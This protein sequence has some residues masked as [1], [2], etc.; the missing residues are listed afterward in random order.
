MGACC[1][2]SRLLA[3]ALLLVGECS[4]GLGPAAEA[5]AH[6]DLAA[7]AQHGAL[8][9]QV[10]AMVAQLV[11]TVEALR[12]EVLELKADRG[13]SQE[14]AAALETRVV[15]LELFMADVLEKEEAEAEARR[16][17]PAERAKAAEHRRLQ[18]E[19][20]C[21]SGQEFQAMTAAAMAACCPAQSA[22]GHRRFLQAS[23]ELPDTCPS[24]AC[25]AIFV[26]FMDDC[27]AIL[28]RSSSVPLQTNLWTNTLRSCPMRKA[29]SVAWS[30]TAGFHQRS[31]WKT[32]FAAVRLR[33]V[34]PALRES[35]NIL[36]PSGRASWK[37]VTM[38]SRSFCGMPPWRNSTV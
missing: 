33:P 8:P 25:A 38:L 21:A 24:M 9:P 4:G 18:A 34:P 7:P 11:E 12:A 32:R 19:Q 3:V 29:R 17:M 16:E 14:R 30:S 20:A 26:P 13:R 37:V 35:T 6:G 22:G 5:A 36:G 23:C 31:K 28:A 1:V 10:Q 27:G 15:E 2:P